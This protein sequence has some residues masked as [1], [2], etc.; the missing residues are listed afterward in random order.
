ML[1]ATTIVKIPLHELVEAVREVNNG[2]GNGD[3]IAGI[4]S[5]INDKAKQVMADVN[6]V[7][8]NFVEVYDVDHILFALAEIDRN[9]NDE[10]VYGLAIAA[11]AHDDSEL[12]LYKVEPSA[13]DTL[14]LHHTKGC[15][16]GLVYIEEG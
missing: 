10:P 2:E 8:I 12:A 5:D 1:Y 15:C 7:N 13:N 16:N 11:F 6:D 9:K 4:L 3:K 14:V